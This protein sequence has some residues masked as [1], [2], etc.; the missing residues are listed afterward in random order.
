MNEEMKHTAVS[1]KRLVYFTIALIGSARFKD[2]FLRLERELSFMGYLVFL[3]YYDGLE[4]KQNYSD[5]QWEYLMNHTFRRIEIA[6]IV[7][8]VNMGGYI[9]EHTRREISFATS[10]GKPV[11]YMEGV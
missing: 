1:K 6:D 9:G 2:E 8:V 5:E 10:I 11:I 4:N 7:Y 3:P